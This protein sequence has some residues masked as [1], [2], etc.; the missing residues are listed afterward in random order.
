MS[1]PPDDRRPLPW[2]PAPPVGSVPAE[3]T[4]PTEQTGAP[5][6]PVAMGPLL[7]SAPAAPSVAWTAPA[8]TPTEV[9]PGLTYAGLVSRVVGYMIDG[10]IVTFVSAMIAGAAGVLPTDGTASTASLAGDVAY[11]GIGLAVGAAYYIVSW[12]GGRRATIG[13]RILAIQIGNAVDGRALTTAQAIRR[14]LGYGTWVAL[15]GL[16]PALTGVAI[17]A[18]LVWTLAV[19]V[20]TATSPTKQGL[21]DRFAG[22]MAVRPTAAGNGVAMACLAIVVVL[23][24]LSLV[25]IVALVFL[26]GQV[27]QILSA[28]GTSI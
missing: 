25:S 14:W 20:T 4:E 12:S 3:P 22:S 16:I 7:S 27:S 5:A 10:F 21:H 15:F 2:E 6:E 11:V 13:Q 9:A 23:V 28:V 8:A 18:S 17:I 19:F 1:Q 26:G 24:L